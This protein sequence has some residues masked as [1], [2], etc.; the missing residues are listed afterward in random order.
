MAI[1]NALLVSYRGGSR[2]VEVKSQPSITT[3]GRREAF[4]SLDNLNSGA[5]AVRIATAMLVDMGNPEQ[6]ITTTVEPSGADEPYV[7]W[8][9]GDWVTTP[10]Q[11]GDDQSLRVRSLSVTEDD[12]GNPIFVPEVGTLAIERQNRLNR[13]LNRM[14]LGTVGGRSE[15]ASPGAAS[16]GTGSVRSRGPSGA[17]IGSARLK[18]GG[19]ISATEGDMETIPTFDAAEFEVGDPCLADVGALNPT[20]LAGTYLLTAQVAV[21]GIVTPNTPMGVRIGHAGSTWEEGRT[22]ALV[23]FD[24]DDRATL[25]ATAILTDDVDFEPYIIVEWPTT[26]ELDVVVVLNIVR[27][28]AGVPASVG[29]G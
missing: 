12:E 10:N 18:W 1:A 2:T 22:E 13:W 27:L 19:P 7:D 25:Q 23:N 4:L 11:D 14:A 9:V 15:S 8:N 21:D 17:T 5:E 20:L 26:G 28:G 16:P 29:E 24:E 6:T 3:H